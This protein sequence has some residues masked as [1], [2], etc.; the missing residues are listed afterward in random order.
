MDSVSESFF[1]KGTRTIP[2]FHYVHLIKGIR[3]NLLTKDLL[4]NIN[5]K[6]SAKKKY[7]SWDNVT[8]LYEM[9]KFSKFKR[10]QMPK[11]TEK[12]I[13]PHAIPKMRVKYA[14]QIFSAT[15]SNFMDVML[16][17]SHLNGGKYYISKL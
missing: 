2:L 10:R 6:C 15:V 14:T 1:I 8:V 4:I 7:A 16:N 17:S 5:E 3:N 9:D 11:I 12:H 13:Y